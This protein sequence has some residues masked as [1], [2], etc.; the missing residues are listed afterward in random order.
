VVRFSTPPPAG[1]KVVVSYN[2]N[3]RGLGACP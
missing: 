2:V 3:V 1:S